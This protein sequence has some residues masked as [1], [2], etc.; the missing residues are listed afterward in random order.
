MKFDISN[1][2]VYSKNGIPA[3]PRWFCDG[4][5]AVKYGN[6]GVER[7]EYYVPEKEHGNQII[8]NQG[9]FDCFRISIKKEGLR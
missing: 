3:M 1:G 4:R 7:I 2:C 6:E 8:F 9:I 5:L